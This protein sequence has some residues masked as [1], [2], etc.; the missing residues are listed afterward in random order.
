MGESCSNLKTLDLEDKYDSHKLTH[1]WPG[2]DD[3]IKTYF[4]ASITGYLNIG[5]SADYVFHITCMASVILYFDTATTP[6]IRISRSS[7][8]QNATIYLTTGRHLMRLYF[9]SSYLARLLVQYSS[10]EAGFPLTT[11]DD[12]V[13]F[14]GGMA[15]SFEERDITTF[16]SGTIET[17]RPC[18]RGSYITS[19]LFLPFITRNLHQ[20]SF[21]SD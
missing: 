11:I 19:L 18:M 21:W 16:I 17:T 7:G 8:M 10:P 20:F 15:P 4:S 3:R 9:S 5:P 6:L 12:T 2:L 14:V 1:T 13:T